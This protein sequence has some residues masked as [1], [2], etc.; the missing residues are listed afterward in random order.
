VLTSPRTPPPRD[1][2]SGLLAARAAQP[3]VIAGR[4]ARARWATSWRTPR[5]RP[6]ARPLFCCRRRVWLSR[7]LPPAGAVAPSA[8]AQACCWPTRAATRPAGRPL[9]TP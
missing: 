5:A 6:P 8:S 3:V 2:F 7:P 9:Q 4:A 1:Y